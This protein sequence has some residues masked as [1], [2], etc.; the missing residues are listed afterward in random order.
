MIDQEIPKPPHR[1]EVSLLKKRIAELERLEAEYKRAEAALAQS[2]ERF[3]KAFYTSPDSI[4]INRLADG[5][6]VSINE[7]FLRITGYTEEEILGKTSLELN[8]W[9]ESEDRRRLI[10]GLK[11][12][13]KVENLDAAFRMK[14]GE[15]RHGLMS[16]SVI[17]LSGVPHILSITRDITHRRRMED[18]LRESEKKFRDLAELLPQGVY[19][20]NG[21]GRLTYA[22]RF[23][24][25]LFGYTQ[26]EL[27]KGLAAADFIA[28]R[29][30]AKAIETMA[31]IMRGRP[32]KVAEY[33]AV[34]KNGEEFPVLIH[35][36]PILK[37]G[38][39]LGIRGIIVDITGR[40]RLEAQLL[41]A[42]KLEAIGTLAG[43]IAHDFNNL[44]MGIQGNM[45]LMAM[46]LDE[47][48]PHR[49]RLSLI[50]DY[51]KRGAGLTRQ[52]LGFARGGR[53][54]IHPADM[55]KIVSKTATMFGRPQKEISIH[56]KLETDIRMVEAD[57]GQ[58]EQVF[59]NLFVNSWQA[60]PDGGEIYLETR[61][62]CLDDAFTRPFSNPSG[63][64]VKVAVTDTGIG[65]DEET[66][67]R[68]FDP[69]FTTKEV[70][71]GTGLGLAM[72]YGIVKG[73]G[74]MIDVES[75]PGRGTTVNIYLP[76][77]GKEAPAEKPAAPSI[78]KGTGTI[79]LVDDEEMIRNIGTEMLEFLGYRVYAAGGGEEAGAIY[80]DGKDE[81]DMVIHD[82]IMPR[83]SGV[84][85]FDRLRA[86]RPD[87]RV[88]LSSGYSVDGQAQK[89]LERGCRG[90]LQ[91][92]FRLEEL[93]QRIQQVLNE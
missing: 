63:A 23:G 2:E 29:D 80:Q 61:N 76:A 24:L 46:E 81:I 28:L 90:F 84:E 66:K 5:M 10:E 36:I 91:K 73:H 16:A 43:G 53:Y 59:L 11:K 25:D 52:L 54:E 38:R 35:S 49:E 60:M 33:L 64:Y 62:V 31:R 89:L 78:R 18:A 1:E 20:A 17:D 56:C 77:S 88:L 19:E 57:E 6:Y 55:N 72:V 58:M 13:G 50:E 34:R 32:G 42:Q 14:N 71:M 21:Q 27:E 93:S 39:T 86:I 67:R 4:N 92:P 44:L 15:L 69:F 22:N 68:I 65:M 83:I 74:G 48:H 26:E 79:L 37:D 87:V 41:Q 85:T 51:V 12:S 82:L 40:K 30:R 70:G 75:E 3:R 45:A 9:A 47:H 7:G 8:I